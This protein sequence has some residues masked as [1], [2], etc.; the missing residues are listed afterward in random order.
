MKPEPEE[1]QWL[2]IKKE[3]NNVVRLP[4]IHSFHGEG[5]NKSM[6]FAL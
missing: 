1:L 4:N 2:N 5:H 6:L 3:Y